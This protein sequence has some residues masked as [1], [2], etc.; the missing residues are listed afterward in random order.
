MVQKEE[1][2]AQKKSDAEARRLLKRAIKEKKRT[3]E[4][5][6]RLQQ[7]LTVVGRTGCLF[8]FLLERLSAE[9]QWSD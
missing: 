9:N 7:S 8:S 6:S 1:A 3:L 4:V 2:L 5:S